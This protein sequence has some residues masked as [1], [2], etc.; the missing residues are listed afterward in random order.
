MCLAA[1]T[2]VSAVRKRCS[3]VSFNSPIGAPVASSN[4]TSMWW[5]RKPRSR[6]TSLIRRIP[7]TSSDIRVA[8]LDL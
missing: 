2:P 6:A 7:V 1:T 4:T 8:P 3:Q 5:E